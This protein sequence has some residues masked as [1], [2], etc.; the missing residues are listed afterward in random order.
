MDHCRN[1]MQVRSS[2]MALQ[3][4]TTHFL[5]ER[6]DALVMSRRYLGED[7]WVVWNR[8]A[9][10]LVTEIDLN[11][12]LEQRLGTPTSPNQ[13]HNLPLPASVKDRQR[14]RFDLKLLAGQGQAAH[15]GKGRYQIQIPPYSSAVL[16]HP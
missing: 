2:S 9:K 14:M 15:V 11:E 1:L 10:P 5:W 4:G 7:V 8:S 13:G 3:Y 12:T 6:P 16:A